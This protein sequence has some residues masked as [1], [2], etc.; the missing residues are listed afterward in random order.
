[1]TITATTRV[2]VAVRLSRVT[3]KGKSRIERDDELAEKWATGR[4]GCEIVGRVLI[5]GAKTNLHKPREVAQR[6]PMIVECRRSAELSGRLAAQL[7]AEN[8]HVGLKSRSGKLDS[9]ARIPPGK[10]RSRLGRLVTAQEDGSAGWSPG[11]RGGTPR[12][13]PDPW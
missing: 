8:G 13:R 6:L 5:G 10:R 1:M 7:V 12:S 11:G 4:Q 2:L 9:P 3:D